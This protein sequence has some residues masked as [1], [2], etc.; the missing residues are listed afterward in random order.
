MVQIGPNSM[1]GRADTEANSQSD[2]ADADAEMDKLGLLALIG[3]A[4]LVFG[5]FVCVN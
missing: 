4:V 2:R 3:M 5:C 1:R